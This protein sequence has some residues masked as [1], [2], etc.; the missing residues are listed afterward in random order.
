MCSTDAQFAPIIRNERTDLRDEGISE[1]L[2]YWSEIRTNMAC[3]SV[4]MIGKVKDIKY[5]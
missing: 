5:F 4:Y 3:F 1:A 2:T